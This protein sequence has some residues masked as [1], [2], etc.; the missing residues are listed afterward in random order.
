MLAH[1]WVWI[2]HLTGAHRE[3]AELQLSPH[4]SEESSQCYYHATNLTRSG[5]P[6]HHW[7]HTVSRSESPVNPVLMFSIVQ[8]RKLHMKRHGLEQHMEPSFYAL[9]QKSQYILVFSVGNV[10]ILKCRFMCPE[11][12]RLL[13]SKYE[14]SGLLCKIMWVS[15]KVMANC[16]QNRTS[17]GH[18]RRK[19]STREC[20]QKPG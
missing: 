14:I 4:N 5:S 19:W 6:V 9:P 18:C 7:N 1:C 20:S 8:C 3:A 16:L 13:K 2:G 10:N 17:V 12:Q 11:P 15:T